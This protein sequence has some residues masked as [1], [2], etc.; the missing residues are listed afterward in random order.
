MPHTDAD[1]R[2]PIPSIETDALIVGAGPVGLF[3]AFQLG[4]LE[5]S[6]HIVDA[7]PYP[8]GQCIELY[9]DKP[10]YDIPGTPRCT[11]RELVDR[12]LE[13]VAPFRPGFHFGQQVASV[14]RLSDDRFDVLTSNGTHFI[15]KVLMVAAGVGA[16]QPKL[17]RVEGLDAFCDTQLFYQVREPSAF[18]GQQ[19][20][21]V[22]GDDTAVRW[23]IHFAQESSH[24][25]RSVTLLHRREL[26]QADAD[27]LAQFETLRSDGHLAFK[28]GQVTS[29]RV[30][31]GRLAQ[32][33]ITDVQGQTSPHSLD[34][35]LVFM[36]LSPKLGPL[37]DWGLT[38]ERKQLCVNTENFMTNQAGIFAVGDIN[39]YPGK[40][41]LI[42]S[43]FHEAALAAFGAAAIVF[44][45]EKKL[46][47]YTTTSPRLHQL[48]QVNVTQ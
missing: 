20:L 10:I 25:A 4:L 18:A 19:L 47:Q 37:A 30:V 12:L 40:K 26:L 33:D 9:P 5:I 21:I 14:A 17:L 28:V 16:F 34:A 22:G 35:M 6:T 13:Q 8:G 27:L 32:V 1:R 39:T 38:L 36:G 46:L 24:Q 31:D 29:G 45:G 43:G 48:L 44:P 3:Q 15:T 23:A 7:L 41:K 11:G 42:L 2:I